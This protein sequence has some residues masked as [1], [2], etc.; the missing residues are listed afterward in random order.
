[1]AQPCDD[2]IRKALN[3]A[4]RLVRL[5]DR[6]ETEAG[7][8]SCAVLY[9]VVR[10]CAWKI[11]VQVEREREAHRALRNGRPGG[12]PPDPPLSAPGRSGGAIG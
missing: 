12:E 5:A 4:D 6:G 3:L 8:D 10:D 7:D 1:M 11:R 9:G 2:N